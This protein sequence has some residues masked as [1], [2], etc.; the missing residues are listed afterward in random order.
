MF[1][2]KKHNLS[3]VKKYL[4]KAYN[5]RGTRILS[6]CPQR[7]LP[8]WKG[9]VNSTSHIYRSSFSYLI[10]WDKNNVHGRWMWQERPNWWERMMRSG[11]DGSGRNPQ[12]KELAGA[13][14]WLEKRGSEKGGHD[15]KEVREQEDVGFNSQMVTLFQAMLSLPW[16]PNAKVNQL[17][18]ILSSV[19]FC[20][21]HPD[22]TS[23]SS[24]TN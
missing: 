23:S 5:A 4:L 19:G 16:P 10:S 20:H 17:L 6:P 7:A 3:Q 24:L 12:K 18:P 8:P 22:Q 11:Q 14:Y 1:L 15:N 2:S 21:Y 13:G 9:M